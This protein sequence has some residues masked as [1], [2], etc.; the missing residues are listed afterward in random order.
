MLP[1]MA[2]PLGQAFFIT[3][4][5]NRNLVVQ[6]NMIIGTT[7]KDRAQ[8]TPNKRAIITTNEEISYGEL[9]KRIL[10]IQQNLIQ[11]LGK[12][13][14]KKIAIF[15]GNETSFLETF[16]AAITLGWIAVPIDP[17][18][19]VRELQMILDEC[20][21]D[22]V[23]Y[24][25]AFE[26]QSIHFKIPAINVNAL[27][28]E[29]HIVEIEWADNEEQIFYIGYTSGSTGKPKGFMRHHR[30]WLE[31]FKGAEIAFDLSCEDSFYA[32]GPLCHSLSLFAA[33]HAIHMGVTFYLTENFQPAHALELLE[34]EPI[35][36]LYAVPTMLYAL[37]NEYR[38]HNKQNDRL[39]KILSSGAKWPAEQKQLV[40]SVF[41][42][43]KRYEF[44]GASELSFVTYL[45]EEGNRK[46]PESVGIPFPNVEIFI[47]REDGTEAD[48]GE[49][50]TLYVKSNLVFSGY[51]NEHEALQEVFCGDLAT[52]GDLA[53]WDEEGYITLVGRKKNM[54]ISGGLNIYPEEVEAHI[55][56]HPDVHEA[57]VIGVKDQYWGE[58]LVALIQW[59]EGAGRS[60]ADLKDYCRKHLASY[61]CPREFYE[62]TQMP[63]TSSGKIA[64]EKAAQMLGSD[65][66]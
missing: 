23:V 8:T 52:V 36:V 26:H 65:M 55:R 46:R 18:W 38:K 49:I 9:Y 15:I 56:K 30:S 31:S 32:P 59:K 42:R 25:Q 41:V 17:K 39:N 6:W 13:K 5:H 14:E 10:L 24:S 7:I 61:K 58:K 50:G 66:I 4:F 53:F 3:L 34:N 57:A 33:V 22:L 62:V 45:D 47:L 51:V 44:Y 28:Q 21:P 48:V 29:N 60:V 64:R 19:S 20:R 43:A 63:L 27:K 16:F 37:A 2:C 40:K 1:K 12:E 54:I 11:I 35:T